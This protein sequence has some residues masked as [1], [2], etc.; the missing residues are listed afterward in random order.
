MAPC[1]QD[2]RHLNMFNRITVVNLQLKMFL[3]A[4]YNYA[5]KK[6]SFIVLKSTLDV[7][8]GGCVLEYNTSRFHRF[9]FFSFF[10]Y[11]YYIFSSYGVKMFC[12]VSVVTFRV[13][14][15]VALLTIIFVHLLMYTALRNNTGHLLCRL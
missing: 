4:L 11:I 15:A 2:G 5:L 7:E 9:L 14:S 6:S 1:W 13:Q 8:D 12:T 10:F 3:V